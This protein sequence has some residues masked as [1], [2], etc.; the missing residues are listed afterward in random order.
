MLP[1]SDDSTFRFLGF[2]DWYGDTVFN[3]LQAKGFLE[4]WQR[5]KASHPDE[6]VL[7][8]RIER[9]ARRVLEDRHGYLKFYGD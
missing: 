4:E 2:I 9:L 5:V 3:Y 7:L 1:S 8:L 6:L